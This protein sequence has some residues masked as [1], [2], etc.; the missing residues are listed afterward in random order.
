MPLSS[1]VNT[2]ISADT[3]TAIATSAPSALVV[4]G[5]L[6]RRVTG[7]LTASGVPRPRHVSA[8]RLRYRPAKVS[9][10]LIAFLVAASTLV[11]APSFAA[12]GTVTD[13]GIT[14]ELDST[15]DPASATVTGY[16]TTFGLDVDIPDTVTKDAEA[17]RV[18]AIGANAF[19]AKF[20]TKV[21]IPDSV[22][23]IG[24]FAFWHNALTAVTIPDSVTTIGKYAFASARLTEV[25]IGNAVTDIG[26]HAF[27]VNLLT[28]V[29]IPDSVITIGE[30][31]FQSNEELI[32]LTIGEAVTD[33][34]DYA[35]NLNQNLETVIIPDSVITIG[36]CAFC[37]N[38]LTA[39]TIGNSVTEIGNTAFADNRLTTVTIPASVTAI[40]DFAF[41]ENALTTVLFEGAPPTTFT[42]ASL[43][44][45]SLGDPTGLTVY[46]PQSLLSEWVADGYD[47]STDLWNGYNTY[48][49]KTVLAETGFEVA[50]F[51]AA[52]LLLLAAGLALTLSRRRVTA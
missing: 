50:P 24:N 10:A 29:S 52:A 37:H 45:R 9:A 13:Q 48:V 1:F 7:F 49:V 5:R 18:I 34:G 42:D 51:G 31:A 27:E 38:G 33:I 28:R 26:E 15:T 14:Y 40:E 39:V 12:T 30:H 32:E 41:S 17:Y 19:E 8:T 11:A 16:D 25:T 43:I 22:T 46:F 36:S 23:S 35:F 21:T 6:R 47:A 44:G 3:S 4:S 2:R 20:L